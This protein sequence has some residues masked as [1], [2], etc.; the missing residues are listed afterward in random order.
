MSWTDYTHAKHFGSG[1]Y[2]P[3]S[4]FLADCGV[5][6]DNSLAKDPDF[7]KSQ[8][9]FHNR[10]TI[11]VVGEKVSVI[12]LSRSMHKHLPLYAFYKWKDFW[13]IGEDEFSY[14]YQIDASIVAKEIARQDLYNHMVSSF[15]FFDPIFICIKSIFTAKG[16][17]EKK[18]REVSPQITANIVYESER[19]QYYKALE[20]EKPKEIFLSHK[21][22]DKKLVRYVFETLKVVGFSPWLDEDKMKAGAVLERSIRDGFSTSCAAVFFVTPNFADEGYL[23]T[24]IDYALEEKRSKG[25][26]FAII[27]L[28]LPDEHG[29]YGTVPKMIQRYVWKQVEPIEIVKTIVEALPIKMGDPAW[30]V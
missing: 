12:I 5:Y 21:S 14:H 17:E 4:D 2:R 20:M 25:D 11:L 6:F 3:Y 18:I 15:G 28:L 26:R 19:L 8:I 1:I 13:G 29:K 27:T 16:D 7:A 10:D 22:A 24:E 23:A 30:R 9:P